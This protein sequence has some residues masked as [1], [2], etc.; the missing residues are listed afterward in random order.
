MWVQGSPVGLLKSR[1]EQETGILTE[2]EHYDWIVFEPMK[3]GFGAY[4][5]YFGRLADG[6]VKARGI[7]A[8]RHDTP[9]FIR[10]MQG[11]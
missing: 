9:A 10:T 4:N 8:R 6:S 7:A 5:R 11:R 1:V 2:V 3:D